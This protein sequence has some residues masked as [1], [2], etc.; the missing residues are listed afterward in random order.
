[1]KSKN[2]IHHRDT[3]EGSYLQDT[4]KGEREIKSL[5]RALSV[6][7]VKS[8]FYDCIKKYENPNQKRRRSFGFCA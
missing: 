6:P 1:M 5:L 3:S 2:Q 7:V 4:E 8:G